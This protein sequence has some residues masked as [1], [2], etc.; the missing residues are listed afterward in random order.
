MRNKIRVGGEF[1]VVNT[2]KN[3][4]EKW[5]EKI[6]NL[7]PNVALQTILDAFFPNGSGSA[8]TN[9]YIGLLGGSPTIAAGDTMSSHAG[10]TEVTAYSEAARQAYND[11]R[12]GQTV[13][14]SASKAT[15]SINANG[16]TI[17]GAFMVDNST[18]G[19]S[20]GL[21]VA[22]AAFTLGN[23]SADSGDTITIQYDFSAADDGA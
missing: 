15:F 13:S 16:T 4:V 10:W 9:L 21:L 1:F 12:S 22:G 2:D 14:N 3:G 5:R 11:V 6:G 8:P 23:K 17:G 18:K 20:T 19:G 7:V